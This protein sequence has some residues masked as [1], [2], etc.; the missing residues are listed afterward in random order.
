MLLLSVDPGFGGQPFQRM[1]L[2]KAALLRGRFP[3][4][5]IMMDGGI[6][7]GEIADAA[8]AAGVNVIVSGAPRPGTVTV[9]PR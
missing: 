8:A 6:G 5:H 9:R 3:D 7:P 4:L 1:V 2:P